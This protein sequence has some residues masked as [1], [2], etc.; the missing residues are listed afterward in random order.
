ME[1]LKRNKSL[2]FSNGMILRRRNRDQ[3]A[4]SDLLT[5]FSLSNPPM[6]GMPKLGKACGA[7]KIAQKTASLILSN[8]LSLWIINRIICSQKYRLSKTQKVQ[9]SI[10]K[11]SFS[12]IFLITK[13]ISYS[14]QR[15]FQYQYFLKGEHLEST[16]AVLRNWSI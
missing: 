12:F 1:S 9:K 15:I 3:K 10:L 16:L 6:W 4:I 11:P 13:S 2:D 8:L 5:I 7:D 14:P